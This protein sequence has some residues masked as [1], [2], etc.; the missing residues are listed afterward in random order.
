MAITVIDGTAFT[1]N[2]DVLISTHVAPAS[3]QRWKAHS[4]ELRQLAA[5]NVHGVV[6]LTL[7]FPTSDPPD[8]TLRAMMQ[9][10]FRSLGDR[11]R[12]LIAVPIGG[13]IWL[14]LVRTIVRSTLL[15]SGQSRLQVVESSIERGLDR[16]LEAA[17]PDTPPRLVLQADIEQVFR[18]LGV[19]DQPQ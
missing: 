4:A 10:D 1:W 18:A 16:V 7:I 6:Y 8:T 2:G 5:R 17:S 19:V 11:L 3:F 13:G 14:A 15:L 9:A 12:K